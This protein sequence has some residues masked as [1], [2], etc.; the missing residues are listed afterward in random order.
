M[1]KAPHF[2]YDITKP[3]PMGL[4]T[5]AKWYGFFSGLR[6][7]QKPRYRS[8]LPVI[9]IG[10]IVMGGSGKTPVVQSLCRILSHHGHHP[11]IL[12]RGYGG[13]EKGPLWVTGQSVK[14]IGDEALLHVS[15]AQTMIAQDRI[16]GAK[17]IEK[18]NS[19][20]HIVMDDG[21]QNP[22][23]EKTLSF[24]VV[25]G[26]NPFGNGA[27]FPSGPLREPIENAVRRSHAMII[28]GE[29]QHDLASRYQFASTIFQATI[30]PQVPKQFSGL[31]II[32]FAGIG[33]PDRF[34]KTL[35][36][37]QAILFDKITFPD[38]HIYTRRDLDRLKHISTTSNIP[39]VTTR[40][41][42]VRLPSAF[43]PFVTVLD[44]TLEWQDEGAL[45]QYLREKGLL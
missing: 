16:A 25:N 40:K 45:V 37:H 17:Q 30:V 23:L 10:N 13:K 15:I 28:L 39:L 6:I 19:L 4:K 36:D 14:E 1:I 7:E 21:L 22:F 41:D 33:N 5:I 43:Q 20:T 35:E 38:H 24:L 27:L 44:I 11:A 18:N 42:W 8:H 9:C 32:A 26:A 3:I 2:W 31:P 29:D 34:F 12:M